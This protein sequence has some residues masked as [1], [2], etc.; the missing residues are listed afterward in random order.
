MLLRRLSALAGV[1]VLACSYGVAAGSSPAATEPTVNQPPPE[2]TRANGIGHIAPKG[3]E[4]VNFT[5]HLS[6]NLASPQSF[7]ASTPGREMRLA[8]KSLTTA[9]CGKVEGGLQFSGQGPGS[10]N[11]KSGYTASFAIAITSAGYYVRHP[12][13]TLTIERGGVVIYSVANAR[14]TNASRQQIS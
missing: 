7:H 10:V 1:V 3:P 14:L 8:V 11:G 13:L 2:C 5:E 12:Y 6:T 4:G 9:S